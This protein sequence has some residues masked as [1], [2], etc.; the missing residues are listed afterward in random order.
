MTLTANELYELFHYDK[1]SGIF[2]RKTNRKN[3]PLGSKAG[4]L[5]KHLGYVQIRVKSKLYLAHRLAW[6][7]V[8][9][10]WPRFQIDHI[11]GNRSD[12]RIDNLRDVTVQ[13]NARNRQKTLAKTGLLGV[14]KSG[15]GFKATIGVSGKNVYLGTFQS[16]LDAHKAYLNAKKIYHKINSQQ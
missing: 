2:T 8:T 7:Y 3:A 14:V 6:L 13:E 11:N 1:Y 16:Q 9:G 10:E 15:S 12:N 5:H 4:S